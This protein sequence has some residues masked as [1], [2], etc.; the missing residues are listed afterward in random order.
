MRRL[1]KFTNYAAQLMAL[2]DIGKQANSIMGQ[3]VS[4]SFVL[5]EKWYLIH[6]RGMV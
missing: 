6:G 3:S 1:L 2:T 5:L 4:F